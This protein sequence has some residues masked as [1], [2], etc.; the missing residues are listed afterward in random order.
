MKPILALLLLVPTLAWS[1]AMS[2]PR[3]YVDPQNPFSDAF[4]AG[5]QKKQVP[6]TL[7]TDSTQSNYTVN[8]TTETDKGSKAR[9]VTTALL[10]GVY[11]NG[12]WDRVSMT[13]I[14]SKSKDVVFSYT[15]QKGGGR[16]QSVAECLAKHWKD[17]LEKR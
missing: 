11:N 7:T 9:G 15:C 6:V 2:R 4:S 17:Q 5:V 1:Q 3:I 8:L 16:M 14:D 10:T 13:V 12:A